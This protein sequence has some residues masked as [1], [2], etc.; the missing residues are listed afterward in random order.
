MADEKQ[1]KRSASILPNPACGNVSFL[2]S[3]FTRRKNGFLPHDGTVRTSK[4]RK[5]PENNSNVLPEKNNESPAQSKDFLLSRYNEKLSGPGKTAR[6]SSLAGIVNMKI[7][8]LFAAALSAALLQPAMAAPMWLNLTVP[9]NG[10]TAG[11]YLG[12]VTVAT[13]VE[14]LQKKGSQALIRVS[15]WS[16]KEYPAQIFKEPGVRIENASFDE[17]KVVKLNPKA[18]EKT[19]QGNVWVKSS[20]QGWVPAKALT[21]NLQGLWAKAKA[22]NAEACATCHAAQPANH[23]TANQWATL[24]PVRGGRAGHTRKGANELMFKWLQE[25][26]KH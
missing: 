14:V 11:D 23:F 21:G 19:V 1:S 15:G 8:H 25:H 20:A 5:P 13:P 9:V 7:R 3:V 10:T 2:R 17:E 24:L 26:A 6:L 22:R 4:K 18:G 16:L 12:K